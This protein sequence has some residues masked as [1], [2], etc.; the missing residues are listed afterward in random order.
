MVLASLLFAFTKASAVT[1][2]TN[3][4]GTTTISSGTF[5]SDIYIYPNVQVKITGTIYMGTQ[6][7]IHIK[8]GGELEVDGGTITGT[9]S[10]STNFGT[11]SRWWYGID[12]ESDPTHTNGQP[13]A[14]NVIA[15]NHSLSTY[16]KGAVYIHNGATIEYSYEGISAPGFGGGTTPGGVII[17]EG[18]SATNVNFINNYDQS[19]K[20]MSYRGNNCSYITYCNFQFNGSY[21]EGHTANPGRAFIFA[22][23]T[24][25]EPQYPQKSTFSYNTFELNSFVLPSGS[26]NYGDGMYGIY[27]NEC[28]YIANWN[29]FYKLFAGIFDNAINSMALIHNDNNNTGSNDYLGIFESGANYFSCI[30]NDFDLV[31]GTFT[32]TYANSAG[33]YVT[34]G[35][36]FTIQESIFGNDIAYTRIPAPFDWGIYA[37]NTGNYGNTVNYNW[38]SKIPTGVQSEGNNHGLLLS[39]NDFTLVY[40]N[41][42]IAVTPG[43]LTTSPGKA[44][45]S[46]VQGTT[47]KSAAN[48]FSE[49]CATSGTITWQDFYQD[50][51]VN[52]VRYY[53]YP[54]T[55]YETPYVSGYSCYTNSGTSEVNIQSSS[56]DNSCALI[57]TT[58][59][60]IGNAIHNLNFEIAILPHSGGTDDQQASVAYLSTKNKFI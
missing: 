14:A 19:I 37:K 6:T 45:I 60:N 34:G 59:F 24:V 28:S 5:T 18:T 57:P 11:P 12:V 10:Y 21:D 47:Y 30:G 16:G 56:N 40:P 15:M 20:F 23:G 48:K 49:S 33:I 55:A 53:Y 51:H 22:Y 25:F 26:T 17:C 4:S 35:S 1:N 32:T 46:N 2:Y 52:P 7:T 44:G 39:C 38:F 58:W 9:G 27:S 43:G 3:T 41:Y 13:P 54:A 36:C 31:G 29:L 50:S 8:P 42:N